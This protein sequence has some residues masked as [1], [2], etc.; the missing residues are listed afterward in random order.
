M[1]AEA[2]HFNR[3]LLARVSRGEPRL[4][5]LHRPDIRFLG[6]EQEDMQQQEAI[7]GGRVYATDSAECDAYILG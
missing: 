3:T 6:L 2:V 5:A 1:C 4:P 7:F